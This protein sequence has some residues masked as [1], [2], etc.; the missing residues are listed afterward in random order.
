MKCPYCGNEVLHSE[1]HCTY[2]GEK[3]EQF[4][5]GYQEPKPAAPQEPGMAMAVMVM[6]PALFVFPFFQKDFA[7]VLY[8]AQY[9]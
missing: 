8:S 5:E 2:C 6:G 3:N 7:S 9:S 1:A 4:I